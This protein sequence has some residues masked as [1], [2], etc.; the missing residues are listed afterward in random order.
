MIL[1]H[2]RAGTPVTAA[3]PSGASSI[4]ERASQTRSST[5]RGVDLASLR[6]RLLR[7]DMGS[8]DLLRRVNANLRFTV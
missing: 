3:N 4:D 1:A 2:V 7:S 5:S 6:G 8:P